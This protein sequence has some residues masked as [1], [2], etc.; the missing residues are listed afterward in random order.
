[1]FRV[2]VAAHNFHIATDALLTHYR[3]FLQIDKPSNSEHNPPQVLGPLFTRMPRPRLP[4]LWR[5]RACPEQ[6]R[7][8]GLDSD[9]DEPRTPTAGKTDPGS[10]EEKPGTQPPHNYQPVQGSGSRFLVYH[11]HPEQAFFAQRK[12]ALSEAEGDPREPRDVSQPALRERE[13]PKG[14]LRHNNRAFGSLPY[15]THPSPPVLCGIKPR[16]GA[17]DRTS[18]SPKVCGS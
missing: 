14:S 11:C 4:V 10:G 17:E 15:R 16:R 5:D 7:R 3:N 12:P 18:A 13:R 1:M 6:S 9:L 8:R 2:R